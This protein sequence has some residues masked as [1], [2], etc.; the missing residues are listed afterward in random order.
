MPQRRFFDYVGLAPPTLEASSF[1]AR[2]RPAVIDVRSPVDAPI[3]S[4]ILSG[5]IAVI[6]SGL[7]KY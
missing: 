3:L 2:L 4:I 7:E 1:V 6:R 5:P